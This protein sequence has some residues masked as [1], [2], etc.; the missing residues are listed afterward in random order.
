MGNVGVAKMKSG[1]YHFFSVY[2]GFFPP[3]LKSW[4][5]FI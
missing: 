3:F 5:Y 1:E 2:F 4:H